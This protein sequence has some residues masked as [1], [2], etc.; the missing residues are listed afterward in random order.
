MQ[1]Q[2]GANVQGDFLSTGEMKR[3]QRSGYDRPV[4]Q[5][6][7]DGKLGAGLAIDIALH[8]GELTGNPGL[9]R[10]LPAFAIIIGVGD[11][12]V[13]ELPFMCLAQD[14]EF[15]RP[16]LDLQ[17]LP[18]FQCVFSPPVRLLSHLFGQHSPPC[19]HKNPLKMIRIYNRGFIG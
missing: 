9:D 1:P 14:G 19:L 4:S 7:Q 12:V 10:D 3:R 5:H 11:H 6:W 16:D 13:I 8:N 15:G 17:A 18:D 2:R